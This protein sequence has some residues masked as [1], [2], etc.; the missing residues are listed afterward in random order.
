MGGVTLASVSPEGV[1]VGPD[2]SLYVSLQDTVYRI[3]Q[4]AVSNA[5][6]HGRATEVVISTRVE[7]GIFILLV[8]D[9]GC[10]F[11]AMQKSVVDG[12]G[13]RTMRY[14]AQAVGAHLTIEPRP[15]G[16]TLVRCRLRVRTEP[17][18]QSDGKN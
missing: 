6:R 5:L 10:G 14:R 4:E 1:R 7:A 2:C 12:M 9:N 13:L 17:N 18:R 3:A 8:E 11:D 16:G 15:G